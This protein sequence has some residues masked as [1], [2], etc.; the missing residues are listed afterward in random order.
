MT[1]TVSN[2]EQ[3]GL[4]A[5]RKAPEGSIKEDLVAA[6]A[7][8]R[9]VDTAERPDLN[10]RTHSAANR[11]A[12]QT[13]T[14]AVVGEFKMGKSSMVNAIA[15]A[16]LCPVDDDVATAKPLEVRNADEPMVAVVYKLDEDE[17][18]RR[19]R[20]IEFED[21]P[22]YVTEPPSAE[23]A[24]SVALVRVGLPR[25]LFAGGLALIDTPGV[26][27]LG[28][29]HTALTMS[30]LPS[31][32]A[33]LF[34]SDASQE[35][36][37]PEIDFLDV[38]ISMC[39]HVTLVMPKIDFYPQWRRIRELNEGHLKRRGLD[40]PIIPVSTV[41]RTMAVETKDAELNAESG[42]GDLVSH[43]RDTLVAKTRSTARAEYAGS[44]RAVL[45]ELEPQLAS[46][47]VVLS[48]PEESARQVRDLE[49]QKES[50]Q[51]LR[52]QAARWQQSLSDG[53]TDLNS[54]VEHDLRS[55]FREIIKDAES[56]IEANDPAKT[57]DDFSAWLSDRV[58]TAIVQN[59]SLLHQRSV[60]L[61][62]NVSTHFDADHQAITDH[63]HIADP[64]LIAEAPSF[65]D[66]GM[67]EGKGA[68]GSGFTMLR[69][70]MGGMVMVGVLGAAAPIAL[71]AWVAPAVAGFVGRK[72]LKEEKERALN[73]RRLQAKQAVRKYTDEA[74]FIASKEARDALR[75]V[76]RQ[77]RDHFMERADEL[78]T[79]TSESLAAAQQAIRSTQESRDKRM[80]VVRKILD[81]IPKVAEQ[82]AAL[83]EVRP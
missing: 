56:A 4:K 42:Y 79:S 50:A 41:L 48:D 70:G 47:L 80:R 68:F 36:T 54:D 20:E 83:E 62:E 21:I 69:G 11:F 67:T 66:V 44:L 81:E 65:E 57:W 12:D 49:A 1:Q 6:K 10:Q 18:K 8:L 38:V 3:S 75:H 2:A 34:V 61:A 37:A 13:C 27:G 71:A 59:Y 16:P 39:Q 45:D 15:N 7:L 51:S 40:I 30:V 74:Q 46:E 64:A 72:T 26:G 53:T 23:D 25:K 55:R 52:N 77:L 5:T 24:D 76:N 58:N 17:S 31:A 43:M 19:M 9:L 60:Q 63:L 82:V 14:V 78:S 28:S 32:D 33:V 73:Q 22:S 35:L 29:T